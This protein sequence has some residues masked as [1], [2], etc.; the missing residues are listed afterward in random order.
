MNVNNPIYKSF[1]SNIE[2]SESYK[3]LGMALFVG[4]CSSDKLHVTNI[5]ELFFPFGSN[6]V[7]S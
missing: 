5:T 4:K 2:P 7:F 6:F 1:A 3:A